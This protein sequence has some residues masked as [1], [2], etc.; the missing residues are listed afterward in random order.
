MSV[1]TPPEHHLTLNRLATIARLVAGAAH[2]VNNA[3]QVSGGSAEADDSANDNVSLDPSRRPLLCK[4]RAR[5]STTSARRS[6]S[7]RWGN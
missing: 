4:P 5:Q 3:L 2:E 7:C 6:G 1:S